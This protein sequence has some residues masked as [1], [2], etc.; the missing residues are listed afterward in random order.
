MAYDY[1]SFVNLAITQIADKGR[2]ISYESTTQGVFSPQTDTITGQTSVT[3]TEKMLVTDINKRDFDKTLIK[4]GDRLGLLANDELTFTPK[5]D[6]IV[7]DGLGRYVV[8]NVKIIQ[9]GDSVV[10]YKL[11]LRYQGINKT[12]RLTEDG[13][14][15]ITEDGIERALEG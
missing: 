12:I 11:Q 4:A 14:E 7:L 2:N 6:D 3:T 15:R 10:L 9:P 1:T 13:I 8:K 5:T